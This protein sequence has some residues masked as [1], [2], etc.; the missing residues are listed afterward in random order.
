METT[1]EHYNIGKLRMKSLP[2]DA[3][4]STRSPSTLTLLNNVLFTNSILSIP[5]V[6]LWGAMYSFSDDVS[7]SGGP[8]RLVPNNRSISLTLAELPIRKWM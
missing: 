5:G 2:T 7:G 1:W 6:Y 8:W 4:M 3:G